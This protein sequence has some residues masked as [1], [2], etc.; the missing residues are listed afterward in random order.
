MSALN[1]AH[2]KCT[3]LLVNE[4]IVLL[5]LPVVLSSVFLINSIW[6]FN[7]EPAQVV[8]AP[9][10]TTVTS[11]SILMI[12]CLGFGSPLPTIIW[13]KGDGQLTNGSD[14][15]INVYENL[16]TE[17]G[18]TLSRSVLEICSVNLADEGEYSCSSV[19]D[20]G[21]DSV[22]FQLLVNVQGKSAN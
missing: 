18:V 13:R 21:N 20:F 9:G 14:S 19:N 22:S 17:S 1:D 2:L 11:G 10:N 15:D 4:Y 12:T 5:A 8:L 7:V 3:G 16:L 6:S